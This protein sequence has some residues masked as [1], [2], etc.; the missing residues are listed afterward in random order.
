MSSIIPVKEINMIEVP[1]RELP[2]KIKQGI[3]DNWNELLK[4]YPRMFNGPVFSMQQMENDDG[5]VTLKCE[6]TNYAHYKYSEIKDLGDY[7]CRNTYAGCIVV[8]SDDKFFVSL[9]VAG[10]EFVGKLQI[11]GGVIDPD[12]RVSGDSVDF[13]DND[14]IDNDD[15]T[16]GRISPVITA[17]RE[18][19]EEAGAEI[20]NSITEI[21]RTYLV[22]NGKKYGI[23]TVVYSNLD[24]E[25]IYSA[26]DSFK[27][28][29]GNNE[30]DKLISFSSDRID[31]L[32]QYEGSQDLDVVDLLKWTMGTGVV[33]HFQKMD[34][35][36]RPHGPHT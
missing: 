7:A 22:T 11:I 27:K 19:E 10:S 33:V 18:L 17:L 5:N 15:V 28:E 34:H 9:N 36:P 20:R 12:D 29:T 31:E 3:Q 14:L 25:A 8:S 13:V 4:T 26:F 24:A 21:G 6:L 30:I 16:L 23:H 1:L 2:G 32:Q 35:H